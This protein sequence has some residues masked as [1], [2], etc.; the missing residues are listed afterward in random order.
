VF[1]IIFNINFKKET[2]ANMFLGIR[3]VVN[4]CRVVMRHVRIVVFKIGITS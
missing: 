1:V 3:R 4:G 2:I